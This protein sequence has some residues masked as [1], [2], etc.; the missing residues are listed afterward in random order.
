M[1]FSLARWNLC[2]KCCPLTASSSLSSNFYVP[3]GSLHNCPTKPEQLN[4]EQAFPTRQISQNI[5]ESSIAATGNKFLEAAF[6]KQFLENSLL[7][8]GIEK[9]KH[10]LFST[11]SCAK[12]FISQLFQFCEE[13]WVKSSIIT[14]NLFNFKLII[15]KNSRLFQS[16]LLFLLSHFQKEAKANINISIQ[17]STLQQI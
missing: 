3:P 10:F 16:R 8:D 15:K 1:K 5:W 6:Q 4:R 12:C 11:S 13:R 9:I 17:L 2:L 14:Q 7:Q